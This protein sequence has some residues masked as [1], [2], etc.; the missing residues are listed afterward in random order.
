M[1][2]HSKWKG[3]VLATLA[4]VLAFSLA[5]PFAVNQANDNEAE[6]L[7]LIWGLAEGIPAL[8]LPQGAGALIDTAIVPGTM[9]VFVLC[10]QA[11][12]AGSVV[13]Y[14]SDDGGLSWRTPS[15]IPLFD[16]DAD[17]A[18]DEDRIDGVDNDADGFFDED[19]P[20]E[21]GVAILPSPNYTVDGTVHV[22]TNETVADALGTVVLPTGWVYTSVDKGITWPNVTAPIPT[23]PMCI[24]ADPNYNSLLSGG[25]IA[26]GGTYNGAALASVW[27]ETW[28]SPVLAWSGGWTPVPSNVADVPDTLALK[29]APTSALRLIAVQRDIVTLAVWGVTGGLAT[30]FPALAA[31]LPAPG[32]TN[33]GAAM[34]YA[35]PLLLTTNAVLALGQDYDPVSSVACPNCPMYMFVGTNDGPAAAGGTN[36]GTYWFDP[37]TAAF[38]NLQA[39]ATM[40]AAHTDTSGII[41]R[42]PYTRA[43]LLTGCARV[44]LTYQLDVRTMVWEHPVYIED[45]GG[46]IGTISNNVG[47]KFPAMTLGSGACTACPASVVFGDTVWA[48][49]T[50]IPASA[51]GIQPAQ[52]P[53]DL[54][55]L[56][57]SNNFGDNWW[58]TC[59]TQEDFRWVITDSLWVDAL[60]GF[61]VCDTGTGI[62]STFKSPAP[63][64][65]KRVD[66]WQGVQRIEISKDG[67]AL[68]LLDTGMTGGKVL[69]SLDMGETCFKATPADPN[70]IPTVM[71][72]CLAAGTAN[73]IAVGDW[74]GHIYV[75]H[76]GGSNWVDTGQVGAK[77]KSLDAPRFYAVV[78]HWLAGID[79]LAGGQDVL[80]S[81]D[82]GATWNPAGIAMWGGGAIALAGHIEAKFSPM[83]NGSTENL[84]YAGLMGTGADDMYRADLSAFGLW[85][86][87]GHPTSPAPISNFEVVHVTGIVGDPACK[88]NII[89]A[90]QAT[91]ANIHASYYPEL[92]SLTVPLWRNDTV[93]LGGAGVP[94]VIS[95]AN[96][97]L[98]N[99]VWGVSAIATPGRTNIPCGFSV[100]QGAGSPGSVTLY[101]RDN[102]GALGVNVIA[103]ITETSAFLTPIPNVSPS[104]GAIVPSNNTATGEPVEL[105]WSAVPG[106]TQYDVMT[107]TDINN[108]ATILAAG[109]AFNLIGTTELSIGVGA[110]V[111]GQTY[112]WRSR[113]AATTGMANHTGPWSNYHSFTVESVEMHVAPEL[114][115]PACGATDVPQ[116]PTF[117]WSGVE[118]AASYDFQLAS[119]AEFMDI[120][121]EQSLSGGQTNYVSPEELD[122]DTYLSW[123]VRAHGGTGIDA[124]TTPWS[125]CVFIIKEAPPTPT[126]PVI[127]QEGDTVVIEQVE[128]DTPAW[129]WV[130]IIIGAILAVVVI[131]LI[132]RTRRPA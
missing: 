68:F 21:V 115:S 78:K 42:G 123:R 81:K 129:V 109:T 124:W 79:T 3:V 119:D 12:G 73:D 85:T 66:R 10:D 23:A 116:R 52:T 20:S 24:A 25:T 60:T 9:T 117:A 32:V 54:T 122:F 128:E 45:C 103:N 83:Y 96:V 36:G 49:T 8:G 108:P 76:D 6:A 88:E 99:A 110:L 18:V 5:V 118:D 104:E 1:K 37:T 126:P 16:N 113:V 67:A 62:Q 15:A 53:G 27:Y 56:S 106:A 57:Q 121:D 46:P 47:V 29:Y 2:T 80:V 70:C 102:G 131:V 11:M 127:V 35:D 107:I 112:Y 7:D 34:I 105:Q 38:V 130:V 77:I 59:L 93:A 39:T 94:G 86:R 61:I 63:T 19:P 97:G 90:M 26:V 91:N 71:M 95:L 13:V 92:L 75:T 30:G 64:Q 33:D 41:A 51:Y 87:M 4:L 84:A 40:P 43:E 74:N 132:I 48:I 58:D 14:R 125:T 22:V 31:G 111:D 101:C 69:V 100:V 65:W 72:T 120:V 50:Q 82:D 28:Q 114:L 89:Y 44:P 55:V 17:G 98:A